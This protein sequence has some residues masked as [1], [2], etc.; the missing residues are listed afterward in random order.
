[1]LIS[2]LDTLQRQQSPAGEHDQAATHPVAIED[3]DYLEYEQGDLLELL[4][5]LPVLRRVEPFL[6]SGG[7]PL[8]DM[9]GYEVEV[10]R[11]QG[12]QTE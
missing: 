5:I 10:T 11:T 1:M 3:K 8:G 7:V 4:D 6:D 9:A 2:Y 12:V